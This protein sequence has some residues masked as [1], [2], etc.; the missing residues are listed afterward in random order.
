MRIGRI[1]I[2]AAAA[3][4]PALLPRC[5]NLDDTTG[6]GGGVINNVDSNKV[7]LPAHFLKFNLDSTAVQNRFSVPG[8]GDSGFG[9]HLVTGGT[10]V[11]GTSQGERAAGFVTFGCPPDTAKTRFFSNG[12]SLVSVAVRFS[13]DT[14]A[15]RDPC[16]VAAAR[17]MDD[18]LNPGPT[19]LPL[20][21]LR[22][23]G[24][25]TVAIERTALRDSI[26]R[27][28]TSTVKDSGGRMANLFSFSI[29]DIGTS[30]SLVRLAG[31]PLLIVT[32][33]RDT[34]RV[35]KSYAAQSAWYI[36]KEN[37]P[38]SLQKLAAP[39]S[40]YASKRTA[41]F[42][43]DLTRLWRAVGP[44]SDNSVFVSAGFWVPNLSGD[45]VKASWAVRPD[46]IH[47]G[48]A[49]DSMFDAIVPV[50]IKDTHNGYRTLQDIVQ[51]YANNGRPP[52]VYLFL[53]LESDAERWK[54]VAW[55][56]APLFTAV[57]FKH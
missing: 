24:V 21:T 9:R 16:M 20:D 54:R 15:S 3:I 55:T 42:K 18:A 22:E 37:S 47:D 34:S 11:L 25:D 40:S 39:V 48:A 35:S 14:T 2:V 7:N 41:V 57:V 46:S 36:V 1:L 27:A 5:A 6:L 56:T 23:S 26:F 10:M 52:S 53:R 31:N 44:L 38:D 17:S 13:R 4:V 8:P 51:A 12:D 32:V 19:Y 49:L 29:I 33:K 50:V 45:S 30:E 28:C 43:Y